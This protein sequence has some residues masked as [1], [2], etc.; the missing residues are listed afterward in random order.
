MARGFPSQNIWDREVIK[1]LPKEIIPRFGVPKGFYWDNG[2]HFFLEVV[3]GVKIYPN[4]REFA[5][6]ME[7]AVKLQDRKNESD[8]WGKFQNY[9]RKHILDG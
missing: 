5:H 2:A 6:S 1:N 4:N 3:E 7:T 8:S 9:F